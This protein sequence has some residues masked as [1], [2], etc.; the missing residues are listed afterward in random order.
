MIDFPR[1]KMPMP[2][3]DDVEI[4]ANRF[5]LKDRQGR[6]REVLAMAV[7]SDDDMQDPYFALFNENDNGLVGI[8]IEDGAPQIVLWTDF[9]NVE[10]V[11]ARGARITLQNQGDN[12]VLE[13]KPKP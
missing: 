2:R 7:D 9:A 3:P 4:V 10:I 8:S 1:F 12:S 13:L 5:V 11:A 6:T